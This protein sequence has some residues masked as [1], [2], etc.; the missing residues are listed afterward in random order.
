MKKLLYLAIAVAILTG[1]SL[2][3][4]RGTDVGKLHPVEVLYIEKRNGQFEISADTAATGRGV[5][6]AD[7]VYDL[8]IATPGNV[9]LETAN[10]LLISPDMEAMPEVFW[11]YLRPACLIYICN[12]KP[13]LESIAKLL[14]SHPSG[15]TLLN[16]RNGAGN[17]P[18][19]VREGETVRIY[20]S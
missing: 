3:P 8:H 20:E 9:F 1:Q 5:T 14:E 18:R 13:A 6:I 19:L 7:A 4:F 10:Y 11:D 2:M 15:V 16:W 12:E 17:I